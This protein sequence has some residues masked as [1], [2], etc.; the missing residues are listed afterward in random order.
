MEIPDSIQ[1]LIV[2]LLYYGN[3]KDVRAVRA[4]VPLESFDGHYRDM[5]DAAMKYMDRYEQPP[6]EHTGEVV[7]SIHARSTAD[8]KIYRRLAA[9]IADSADAINARYIID[10]AGAFEHKQ[11]IV[12]KAAEALEL[13]DR[14]S[15]AEDIQRAAALLADAAKNRARDRVDDFDFRQPGT[16]LRLL[17]DEQEEN[18]TINLGIPPYDYWRAGPSRGELHML[19]APP[20][21]YKS[22]WLIHVGKRAI[23]QGWRVVHV[24]IEINA[25]DASRR[26]LQALNGWTKRKVEGLTKPV[27]DRDDN[28]YALTID[29]REVDAPALNSLPRKYR[30]RLVASA[31]HY[32]L[33]VVGYPSGSLTMEMLE[34]YLNTLEVTER[35]LPDLLIV[36]YVD[37]MYVDTRNYRHDVGALYTA[38]RGLGQRRNMAVATVSQANREAE[39]V[40]WVTRKNAAEAF[41]KIAKADVGFTLSR[42]VS[43]KKLGLA[44]LNIVRARNDGGEQ[45]RVII[46]QS[47]PTGQ[48]VVDWAKMHEDDY[49]TM[50]DEPGGNDDGNY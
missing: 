47:I 9:S 39:G 27:F 49:W 33:R 34:G 21:S 43:E 19:I 4:L 44:R 41:N 13:I 8:E 16:L 23:M 12:T 36:D 35:Y 40:K 45:S 31:H 2:A 25:V 48:F 28:G 24:T 17:V 37:E 50:I 5:A 10:T 1:E 3:T 14:S 11:R 38:L 15:T 46:G 7:Q 26:Y 6:G 30:R 42:T 22:W 18:N 32:R 29:E 20:S